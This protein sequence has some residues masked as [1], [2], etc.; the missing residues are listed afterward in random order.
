MAL[1]VGFL[2]GLAAALIA[3]IL[4]GIGVAVVTAV[5]LR[6]PKARILLGVTAAGF[7]LS[8]GGYIV[9]SQ[10]IKP[11][12]PNGGWPT[13]F[14]PADVLVW[15]GVL[16]LGAD[17]LIE[18]VMRR[19]APTGAAPPAGGEPEPPPP[20]AAAAPE[21]APAREEAPEPAEVTT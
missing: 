6:Y 2:A 11:L 18:I 1:W 4:I 3:S 19:I 21:V 12:A 17:G 15:A 14:A 5:A 16:L 13:G 10:G 9:V 7:I 20:P 8:P